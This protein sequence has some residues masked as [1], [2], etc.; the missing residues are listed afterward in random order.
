MENIIVIEKI[1]VLLKE[2]EDEGKKYGIRRTF[3]MYGSIKFGD[4]LF[5]LFAEK[6]ITLRVKNELPTSIKTIKADP[7]K[8]NTFA[9]ENRV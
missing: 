3:D 9:G 7:K 5:Y 8:F 2:W 4:Q 1:I 6:D